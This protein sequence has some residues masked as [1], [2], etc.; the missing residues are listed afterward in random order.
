MQPGMYQR[1]P[2]KAKDGFW[3]T[4]KKIFAPALGEAAAEAVRAVPVWTRRQLKVQQTDQLAR[5]TY[6]RTVQGRAPADDNVVSDS[7]WRR[8]A[9]RIG[10]QPVSNAALLIAAIAAAGIIYVAK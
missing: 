6:Q 1:N 9:F 5:P 10:D 4:V 3:G 7:F 2:A 8:Q